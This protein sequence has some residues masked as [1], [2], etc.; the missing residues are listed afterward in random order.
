MPG[1]LLIRNNPAYK[2]IGEIEFRDKG[3]EALN[4]DLSH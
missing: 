3:N 4:R 2:D 1:K